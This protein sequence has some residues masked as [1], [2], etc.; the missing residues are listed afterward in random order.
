MALPKLQSKTEKSKYSLDEEVSFINKAKPQLLNAMV[1]GSF[2]PESFHEQSTMSKSQQGSFHHMTSTTSATLK[3][4][5]Q[6]TAVGITH[7]RAALA[8]RLL[9]KDRMEKCSSVAN[10]RDSSQLMEANET[11]YSNKGW[12]AV[13]AMSILTKG[14]K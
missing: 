11:P 9:K 13:S 14:T 2:S 10:I 8:D 5:N 12:G 3:N 7:V 6:K 4:K 1:A